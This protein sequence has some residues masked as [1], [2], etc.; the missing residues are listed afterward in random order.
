MHI[1]WVFKRIRKIEIIMPPSNAS[2]LASLFAAVQGQ[3]YELTYFDPLTNAEKTIKVY[4]S[5][6]SGDLYSGVIY[7]GLWQ[8]AGF[9]AIEMAGE[10]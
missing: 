8:D 2:E 10:N 9:N 4:T 6:S 3:E 1:Y 7:N 5:N